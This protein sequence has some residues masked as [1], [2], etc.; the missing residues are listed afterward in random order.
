[1]SNVFARFHFSFRIPRQPASFPYEKTPTA[2][3]SVTG[4]GDQPPSPCSTA[5]RAT[6]VRASA[7]SRTSAGRQTPAPWPADRPSR[8]VRRPGRSAVRMHGHSSLCSSATV[9][10]VF[11][12]VSRVSNTSACHRVQLR[13]G[14]VEHEHLWPHDLGAIARRCCPPEARTASGRRLASPVRPHL[15]DPG[16]HLRGATQVSSEGGSPGR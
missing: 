5:N 12:R 16:Q 7:S 3:S 9:V 13:C 8:S 15:L 1:V 4:G 10:P 14:F 11:V 2:S 6:W